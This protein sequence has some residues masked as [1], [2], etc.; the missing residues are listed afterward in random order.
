MIERAERSPLVIYKEYLSRG[1]L[2]Y[3]WDE[4]AQKAVFYPR[5]FGPV[6]GN[7]SLSWRVSQGVGTVYATTVIYPREGTAYNIA[8]IDIDEGYRLMSRVEG[9]APEDVRIGMRVKFRVFSPESVEQA[10][11][12]FDRLVTQ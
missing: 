10:Y 2:A 11:P 3:Q 4:Q 5:L 9:L 6:T 12:V 8:L 7:E 1:Q